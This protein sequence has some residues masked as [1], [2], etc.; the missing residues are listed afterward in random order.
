MGKSDPA[1]GSRPAIAYQPDDRMQAELCPDL[2][3]WPKRWRFDDGDLDFGSRLLDVLTPFMRHLL[4]TNLSRKTL[5]R[6]RD[7]LWMLGGELVRRLYDEPSLRKKPATAVLLHYVD[8]E[9]GPLI[10]PSITE[11][12]QRAFD[13]TCRKLFRFLSETGVTR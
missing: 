6:H 3:G 11:A 8:D 12:Q 9:G 4:T 1:R 5:V 13:A 10:Y 7:H 2:A